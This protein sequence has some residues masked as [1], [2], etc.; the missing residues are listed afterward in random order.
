MSLPDAIHCR[1]FNDGEPVTKVSSR[2]YLGFVDGWF[3]LAG[4]STITNLPH[5][6][7]NKQMLDAYTKEKKLKELEAQLPEGLERVISEL[8]SMAEDRP[9]YPHAA[10]LLARCYV[11]NNQIDDSKQML[12]ALLAD[13]SEGISA[14]LELARVFHQQGNIRDAIKLLTEVTNERPE[15]VDN[16]LLLNEYLQQD[17]QSQAGKNALAQ[18]DM[19]NAFNRN[20]ESAEKAYANGEFAR[21]DKMCR[22]LL[23]QVPGEFRVLRLLARIAKQFRHFEIS[24]S[25]LAMCIETR[26]ADAGLGLDY[27]RALLA[28]KKFQAALEQCDRLIGFAP[29]YIDVY[30]VKAE[31]LYN[32]GRYGQAIEIFRELSGVH[33]DRELCQ[34]HLGKVL[35][36]VGE[37]REAIGCFHS[38]IMGQRHLGQAYFE[39]ANLKTYRFSEDE[40]ES[41]QKLLSTGELSAMNRMLIQFALGKALEDKGQFAESF[42]QYH[43]A[44]NAYTKIRPYQY[45]SQNASQKSFFTAEFFSAQK[46]NGSDS[47]APIFVVGLPRSGSTLVEQI[48]TSHSL[49]DSTMELTGIT[50]IS[51]ELNGSSL[52]GKGEY[53][54]SIASLN[55][56]G[57]LELAQKYLDE[58]RPY[59]LDAP[60]FVDK[61]PANFHYIGLIKTLFPNVKIIDIRRHPLASGWSVYKHFFADSFL[62]SYDLATIGKYYS[63]Y[64]DL[65]EHWHRVLPGQI[66]TINYEDLIKDFPTTLNV[67]LQ[68]CE[69]DFEEACL[70]FHLNRRAVATPSAEQVRQPIYTKALEHWKNYDEFLEPLKQALQSSGRNP[71]AD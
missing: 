37:T 61:A 20:L 13:G 59:R 68:Y 64:L 70:D 15:N 5:Y 69:L 63:D 46:G 38:A 45:T 36:T 71:E 56:S 60:H 22:S 21:A 3:L 50:S 19:I 52:P 30:G 54:Q 66:L 44:N 43:S 58:A 57:I 2:S 67:L 26:P 10:L 28:G 16:W 65:M 8:E 49:V 34:V 14:K 18:C 55:T 25:I 11:L 4:H 9:I 23:R 32:L 40:I 12:E 51:R 31:A 47:I 33:E 6:R 27:A 53:P 7:P 42:R 62:F 29:E 1:N 39:L 24:T 17:G 48:L 35:K 41:M